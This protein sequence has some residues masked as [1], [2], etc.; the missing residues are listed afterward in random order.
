MGKDLDVELKRIRRLVFENNKK[1][2][3][4]VNKRGMYHSGAPIVQKVK[5][6]SDILSIEVS[7]VIERFHKKRDLQEIEIFIDDIIVDIQKSFVNHGLMDNTKSNLFF[8]RQSELKD[9]LK[10]KRSHISNDL[11]N[12]FIKLWV[13]ILLSIITVIVSIIALFCK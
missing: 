6:S 11:K 12:N 3:V 4:D 10:N 13:P 5:E 1:I 9:L 8:E 7:K 2:D